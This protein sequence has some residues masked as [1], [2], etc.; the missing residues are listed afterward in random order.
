LFL[1]ASIPSPSPE[2]RSFGF[3]V[4]GLHLTI[5]YYAIA[6]LIGIIAAVLIT[7]SRLTKRGGEKWIIIDILFGAIPG[8]IIGA[9]IY[10]VLTHPNDYFGP[11]INTWNP[12]QPGSVWA[13]W[14][15]GIAIFGAIIGGAIGA[16]I[17]CRIVGVRF[18]SFA[19]AVAPAMLIAQALGRFGNYFNQ[20]LYGLPTDL[21]WGLEIQKAGNA[22]FPVG[23][24][25]GTLFHP[26]FLYEMLWNIVGFVLILLIERHFKLRWGK[27][28]GLYLIWYGIGRSIFESIRI[29]PS[30]I[31][32]G[33]RVN[34][35]GAIVAVLVG[36]VIII[37]QSRRHPGGEPSVYTPEGLIKRDR[38]AI[39]DAERAGIES[40][41]SDSKDVEPSA[42]DE[43]SDEDPAV[44]SSPTSR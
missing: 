15:G 30:E 35:W 42:D 28:L 19:D 23:L 38:R 3:D 44:T 17:A 20:E 9:R 27:T 39:A 24:P 32:L 26:T 22:A 12:F 43:E 16:A 13:I 8:G 6:I 36:I 25:D 37:V 2:W 10:H 1:P 21:P 11:G 18:W 33:L 31:F 40:K 4:F 14:E 29:D 5:Y 7:N 34:I 41:K